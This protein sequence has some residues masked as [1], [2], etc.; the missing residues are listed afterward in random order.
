MHQEPQI[1]KPPEA[2]GGFN[3]RRL[4]FGPFD[5]HIERLHRSRHRGVSCP[6]AGPFRATPDAGV[7]IYRTRVMSR[8]TVREAKTHRLPA[9]ALN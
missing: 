7:I 6:V 9:L 4:S 8:D 5:P 2:S 1:K 3:P